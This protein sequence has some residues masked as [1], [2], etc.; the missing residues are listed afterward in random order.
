MCACVLLSAG[1][2]KLLASCY[3]P[4]LN[5]FY[6]YYYYYYYLDPGYS[7]NVN[8]AISPIDIF[9]DIYA[10]AY[11]LATKDLGDS[12]RSLLTTYMICSLSLR[13]RIGRA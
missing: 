13:L 12:P 3:V 11:Y 1:P 9:S 5:E 8:L 10:R 6:Y 4:S 7:I 2:D